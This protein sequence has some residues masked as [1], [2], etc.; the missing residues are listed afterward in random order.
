MHGAMLTRNA[1]EGAI[2]GTFNVLLVQGVG[3]TPKDFVDSNRFVHI[4]RQAGCCENVQKLANM[5]QG[6]LHIINSIAKTV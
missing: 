1:Q 3:F 2:F 5:S 4:H 6:S